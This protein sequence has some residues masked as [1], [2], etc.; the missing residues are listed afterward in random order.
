[1]SKHTI[2]AE[3]EIIFTPAGMSEEE[4]AYP[5]LD[6]EFEYTPGESE[7]GPT[8]D[9]GGT[10]ASGAQVEFMGATVTDDDGLALTVEQVNDYAEEWLC[11]DGYQSALD[12]VQADYERSMPE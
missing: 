2:T 1:M 3:I 9:C 5:T 8:Y 11:G 7:T 10:P 6:I 4:T 12:E